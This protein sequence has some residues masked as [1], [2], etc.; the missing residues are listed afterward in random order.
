[1]PL[2]QKITDKIDS[3][4]R[5]YNDTIRPLIILVESELITF[6]IGLLNE[7]RA[8]NDHISRAFIDEIEDG[9]KHEELETARR[10]INRS[11]YECYK[12]LLVNED[13]KNRQFL[14][15][16]RNIKLGD[17]DSGKF[18]PRFKE[19]LIKSRELAK[20]GKKLESKGDS[21]REKAVDNFENAYLGYVELEKFIDDSKEK[22][23]WSVCNERKI[24]WIQLLIGAIFGAFITGGFWIADRWQTII[25]FFNKR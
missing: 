20:E 4:Y 21:Y 14:R 23:I 18:Y 22:L 6:P 1:M 24:T 10:H 15:Q 3:L 5:I 12:V 17:V 25:I 8:F 16:Y 11:K 19:L 13:I 7:I 2:D 9:K